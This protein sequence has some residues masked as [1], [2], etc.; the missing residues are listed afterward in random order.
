MRS[1]GD[2]D[3]SRYRMHGLWTLFNAERGRLTAQKAMQILA[4]HAG[5]PAGICSHMHNNDPDRGTT[6]A[7]VAEPTRGLLH[8]TRGNPCCNWPVTFSL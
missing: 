8:A 4:D 5:Y 3:D 7:I 6:A 2:R 1:D